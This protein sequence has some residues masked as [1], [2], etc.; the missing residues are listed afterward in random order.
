MENISMEI[1]QIIKLLDEIMKND[2]YN[3]EELNDLKSKIK[4]TL[5]DLKLKKLEHMLE[6]LTKKKLGQSYDDINTD[7]IDK[8]I[9][10]LTNALETIENNNLIEINNIVNNFNV[11]NFE[12][13][14]SVAPV[15]KGGASE[16]EFKSK[17]IEDQNFEESSSK[18]L[19]AIDVYDIDRQLTEVG[20]PEEKYEDEK[21]NEKKEKSTFEID[22]KD[23][24]DERPF[25]NTTP[26]DLV[27][28]TDDIILNTEVTEQGVIADSISQLCIHIYN[29]VVN[30][31]EKLD[32]VR[33][34]GKKENPNAKYI[35][36]KSGDDEKYYF[37]KGID[38][39]AE[40]PYGEYINVD[41]VLDAIQKYY[42]KNRNTV[43]TVKEQNKEFSISVTK[44][45]KIEK[46]LKKC[47]MLY[48]VKNKK[49]TKG[50]F[51]AVYGKK[52]FSNYFDIKINDKINT[53]TK[54]GT[55]V[56]SVDLIAMLSSLLKSKN[57]QLEWLREIKKGIDFKDKENT[58]EEETIKHNK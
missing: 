45:K 50:D 35:S 44:L 56:N 27:V 2:S 42:E 24:I 43:Y 16:K 7:E 51:V 20:K 1:E 38:D 25:F 6:I 46:L 53:S 55:Y 37:H 26:N 14:E 10:I 8:E 3:D 58:D 49:L 39:V 11:N 30:G 17:E 19:K 5:N 52:A 12:S 31:I 33:L 28:E 57:K 34:D 41:E 4:E 21:T 29:D 40:L 54:E 9:A 48:L 23:I 13:S 22:Y 32:K 47:N 15:V 18:E 36:T